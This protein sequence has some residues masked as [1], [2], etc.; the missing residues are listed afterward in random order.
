MKDSLGNIVMDSN[1]KEIEEGS[2]VA[3]QFRVIGV[4]GAHVIAESITS[5]HSGLPG[6]VALN[7][8]DVFIVEAAPRKSK[9][10]AT[11]T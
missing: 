10:A 8:K 6:K 9:T 7:P 1:G 11:E 2:I 4:D 5:G 3:V